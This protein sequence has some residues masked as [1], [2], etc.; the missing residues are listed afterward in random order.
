MVEGG[1]LTVNY[2]YDQ[3]GVLCYPDLIKVGVA[4]DTGHIMSYDA[5]GYIS[6]HRE[7]ELPAAANTRQEARATVPDTLTVQSQQLALIP[8]EGGEERLCHELV[9]QNRDGRRYILYVNAVTGAQEK[10]LIL[11]E[12][13]S[14]ALTV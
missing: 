4:L 5:R 11:L 13:E 12:D 2:A 8:S 10:I 6:S 9:C 3:D 7:R 14:G 1:V